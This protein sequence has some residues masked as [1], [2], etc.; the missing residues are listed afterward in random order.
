MLSTAI[1]VM[2]ETL[3]TTIYMIIYC[4]QNESVRVHVIILE[5][6]RNTF[7]Y[8][9]KRIQINRKILSLF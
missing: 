5:N 6:A 4:Q 8:G 1:A 3:S 2:P 9:R 7:D